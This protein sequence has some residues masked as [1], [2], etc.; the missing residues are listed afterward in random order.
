MTDTVLSTGASYRFH[1]EHP[2]S[3]RKTF[4]EGVFKG[5]AKSPALDAICYEIACDP[6]RPS[7]R[8]FVTPELVS[9]IEAVEV[10]A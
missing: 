1:I 10:V 7:S 2:V 3:G 4:Y 6:E 5:F 8:V 9:R